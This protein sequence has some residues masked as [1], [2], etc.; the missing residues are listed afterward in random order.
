MARNIIDIGVQGNDGTGDSIRESFRKVN[1]NFTQLFAIFGDG[2]RI[3][4][5]DL[6]DTPD[7]YLA[8]Q[9]MAVN[10]DG[11]ALVGKFIVGGDGISI[12]NTDPNQIRV[13]STGG[14]VEADPK[15]I[16]GNHLNAKG[17][18][19]ANVAPPTP[20]SAD[21]FQSLHGD[22]LQNLQG[23]RIT[24]D[25]IVITKG[26]ADKTYLQ[27]SGG[28]GSGTLI[29]V[30]DEPLTIDAYRLTVQEW[31]DG[32]AY[33]PSHGF[34]NGINGAEFVYDQ[35]GN[36]P[37]TGLFE[38][39][40]YYLRY[41]DADNLAV[42]ALP[43][44][45]TDDINFE[46]TRIIVND[47]AVAKDITSVDT[48]TIAGTSLPNSFI[49]NDI[50]VTTV[51]GTGSGGTVTITKNNEDPAYSSSNVTITF[52]LKGDGYALGD[53]LK[54][55][56]TYLGGTTPA[57]DLTF[58]LVNFYRGSES[59][60]DSGYD[61]EL[62][63]NWLSNEALPRKSVV[64][65]QGDSME[66]ALTLHD[67]PGALSGLGTPNGPDDLQAATKFYVDN[68]SYSSSSNL[69]VT[70]SGNDSQENTPA[71]KEGS[72]FSYAYATVGAA[73]AKAE[74][75]IAASLLEPG[76]YRQQMTYLN[77]A[78]PAYIDSVI[79]NQDATRTLVVFT[80]LQG[81]DQSID[82]EN[83]DLREGSIIKGLRSGA[84][85]RVVQYVPPTTTN[86]DRYIVELL[87]TT[88]DITTFQTGFLK[89]SERI[90][91][92]LDF[93]AEEVIAYIGLRYPIFNFD[94]LAW[95]RDTKAI[96][97]AIAFDIK[98]GG[99]RKSIEVGRSYWKNNVSLIPA[100]Q[101]DEKL[102]S[103]DYL[104]RI[105]DEIIQNNILP[106]AT[107]LSTPTD[108]VKRSLL[109]QD[110]NGNDGELESFDVIDRMADLVKDIIEFGPKGSGNFLEFLPNEY[111]EFGQP[112][113]EVQI[114]VRVESGVYYEQLPIRVPTNVSIKGD[115][116]RRSIIRPAPGQS[117]SPW[118]NIFFRRDSEFDGIQRGYVS[119]TGA[120]S[121]SG[122]T[123]T[124]SSGDITDQ[125]KF[126]MNVYL[127]SGNG[128]LDSLTTVTEILSSTSF[129]VSPAPTTALSGATVRL[130]NSSGV[131]PS[132]VEFG[133]HYLKDPTGLAGIFN[134]AIVKSSGN[135][136]AANV[137]TSSKDSLKSS[138]ISYLDSTY[139]SN[140]LTVAEKALFSRDI[141]L[142]IDAIVYDITYGGT[143]RS[144]ATGHSYKT[145]ISDKIII[146]KE[147]T[148]TIN[149]L[150][151]LKT[152]L[153][154]TLVAFPNSIPLVQDL[155]NGIQNIILGEK[156]PPKDN[157]DMDVFMLND[158]CILRNITAQGHGGF[159]CVL[160]PEGQIQ[161]KSPYFQ[162]CTSLSGSINEQRF[163]GG[164][165]IDG[166]S[167]NLPAT[168]LSK[169]SDIQLELGGL[170]YRKPLVPTSFYITGT[171]YQINAIDNWNP[172]AGTANVILDSST[173]YIATVSS[174]TPI[175]IE[176]PG[177]RSMLSN[178][179]TQVNDLGYGLIATN[180]GLAEA[181]SVFSYYNW[182]SY[183]SLNGGQ[184]RSVTGNSSYGVYGLRSRGSDPRE[185][186]DLVTLGDATVQQAKIYKAGS[187]TAKN[188]EGDSSFYITGYWYKPFGSS[189]VEIDHTF[190]KSSLI[191]T[192]LTIANG[193]TGYRLDDLLTA[194]GGTV[195]P[196]PITGPTQLVVTE[197]DG[198]PGFIGPGAITKVE[199]ANTGSYVPAGPTTFT[200]SPV[201]TADVT[202]T[203]TFQVTGGSGNSA[204]FNGSFLGTRAIYE[205]STVE[206]TTIPN[207]Y[208][209]NLDS[210]GSNGPKLLANLH[211][212][213]IVTV[214]ALQNLRFTEVDEVRPVRPSTALEFIGP[215]AGGQ[216]LRTLNYNLADSTGTTLPVGQAILNFDQSFD[217]ALLDVQTNNLS[218]GYG[219]AA[220]DTKLAIIPISGAKLT[221]VQ[222]GELI[223]PH[224]GRMHRITGYTA[225][226]PTFA[227]ITFTN[228]A[229]GSGTTVDPSLDSVF[230]GLRSGFTNLRNTTI[231]AG[232]PAGTPA[233]I[234]VRI[235]TCRATGHDF[236]D[237]GS[238]GFNSSNYP[239]NIYGAPQVT[240]QKE[241]EVV[242]ETQGR[243]FY[244]STDQNGIFKVGKFFEVDQGTGNVTFN[245]AITLTDLN[246]LGFKKG[247]FVTEFSTDPTLG[248]DDSNKV[249]VESAIRGYIDSRL[250]LRHDS[251][252]NDPNISLIGP[253]YLPLNGVLPL[254]GTLNMGGGATPHS[255][256]NVLTPETDPTAA[257]NKGYVDTLVSQYDSFEK[258]KDVNIMTP[259]AADIVM[260]TG[261]GRAAST[262]T[263]GGVISATV[264][265]SNT[266]SL[267]NA[268]TGTSQGSVEG[269]ITVA[270]IT[271]FP[272]SGHIQING[273]I[274]KYTTVDLP[275]N[276]F[277]NVTRARFET[278]A[279]V[280][281]ANSSVVSLDSAFLNL[282]IVDGSIINEDISSTAAIS[283]S[284]LSMNAATTRANATDITQ[285]DLGL[286]SFDSANF[287]VTNG[288][289]GIKENGIALGEIQKIEAG[290]ILGNF[291]TESAAPAEITTANLVTSGISSLFTQFD[292][293]AS[294]MT[295]RVNSLK[296]SPSSTFTAISGTAIAG[297][298]E[299]VNIPV[300]SVTG[301][302]YGARVNV[303]YSNGTYT[304]ITVVYGGNGYAEGNQLKIDGKLLN[305][306]VANDLTFT[307][308][309][310][311]SNID[312]QAYL[313]LQRVSSLAEA[314]SL[315]R[316]DSN[317]NLGT[318]ANKFN[319]IHAVNFKGNADSADTLTG[320]TLSSNITKSSLTTLGVLELVSFGV[321]D[322]II[323]SG[324]T[325]LTAKKLTKNINIITTVGTGSPAPGVMLPENSPI[326]F[327]VIVRNDSAN[328]LSIYPNASAKINSLN[329]NER[330]ILDGQSGLEFVCARNNQWYTLSATFA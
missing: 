235:S 53:S 176:T 246:G 275:T 149:S 79:V 278:T 185:V 44:Q 168:I 82:I 101:L 261:A 250:G 74:E 320:D 129:R 312:T 198:I 203:G 114:T 4:F 189:E 224:D 285:A 196:N 33:I 102:D 221:R 209:L 103:I 126:G 217:S 310:T 280:H 28:A 38:G 283:Q 90:T 257:T 111:L 191:E 204:S 77:N 242:E 193:G 297:N 286:A 264:T 165:L 45:A 298:D 32:Y 307:V 323:A 182:T 80:Q 144:E 167:G 159:M 299:F 19:I 282:Q 252:V 220:G 266:N 146:S 43:N 180:N 64:R 30:R 91:A 135:F 238:G 309:S 251:L 26:F 86:Q 290:T 137:L 109:T 138:V 143:S 289:V 230:T 281:L 322:D 301:A 40:K 60:V 305:G 140:F 57:N 71:G 6:D 106:P 314:S 229:F 62:P 35:T 20:N 273:E 288:W 169:T 110:V 141:G 227:Y 184:I 166:F 255:I 253:G 279:A 276:R 36:F 248:S 112:V 18:V 234:T 96:V 304:L 179:Y 330:F 97:N 326:G 160:D 158:G 226:S 232:L 75:I 327:R 108:L 200:N 306:T 13:V 120:A 87:H 277:T 152:L 2:D 155:V 211:N 72:S 125:V 186:P 328:T 78:F 162:T 105:V 245:A 294:V 219:S 292:T 99:N 163:A 50:P 171:R 83:R 41:Y 233:K 303:S 237:V 147:L 181:V 259:V 73:C 243:V 98:F 195:D 12:D 183:Y 66:G 17:L 174:T 318:V 218:G 119:N 265:S 214:R 263:I 223:F 187:L 150:T 61:F 287:E 29:R 274:F 118:T 47:D 117:T 256:I 116:F 115:E 136:N 11:D 122:N 92:N 42:Y 68:S 76:P 197:I 131:A 213:Q 134:K 231:R 269:G 249:P 5:T 262:G 25:D 302:G 258:L 271:G 215:A 268:I 46:F 124:L 37:A 65:R 239:N 161:T 205:T 63:G 84:T 142:I 34:N 188:L 316:T 319:N 148:E 228:L 151:H 206:E 156:N 49:Y 24:Q 104:L 190:T 270:D 9:V 175:E 21:L 85:G 133:Y 311:G 67:H 293:G 173:P 59:L 154:Q 31:I 240:P 69:F 208:K 172:I 94:V 260:F 93:I 272:T 164:M 295:R 58:N 52:I 8:N 325:Q 207:V 291:T 132:G 313:G 48:S 284:K 329:L 113:P 123:I 222:S 296:T 177:N 127:V 202:V 27:I 192:S 130:L 10:S 89:A 16:L 7:A 1:D 324:N 225:V 39:Q 308:A 121:S 51:T 88:T 22:N 157:K 153:A 194:S 128:L 145:N 3:A 100:N 139:G 300:S 236:L 170:I 267:V 210:S 14:T 15:P 56:G 95:K 317:R 241:K 216:V 199:I 212:D 254:S 247:T 201:G 315:V 81:V 23:R 55:L 70:T 54:I 178:D 321:E 244:V 107:N